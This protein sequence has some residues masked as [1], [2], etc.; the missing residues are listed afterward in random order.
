MK[1]SSISDS[2][3]FHTSD[4]TIV[5]NSCDAYA[6]VLGCFFVAFEKF[7]PDCPYPIVINTESKT[8]AR[9]SIKNYSNG[10]V[11][12]DWGERFLL[13]LESIN[14]TYVLVLY[15]DFIL[16][17]KVENGRIRETISFIEQKPEAVVAYLIDTSLELDETESA[18]VFLPVAGKAEYRLN[19]APAIWRRESLMHYTSKGDTPWAWEAFGTYRTFG[20]QNGF[21]S[22][23]PKEKSIYPY[24]HSKGGAIYRGK[25]VKDVVDQMLKEH[26]LE[27]NW[28]ERGF[29]SDAY[30]EKRSLMWKIRFLQLGFKMVGFKSIFFVIGYFRAK[31][32]AL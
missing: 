29:S 7:W 16:N 14:T 8:Y 13:S 6:D 32:N 23:N 30:H 24:N 11:A 22:L 20:D 17:A 27:V 12:D 19:S 26:E 9:G 5:I 10:K 15:D 31:F 1:P 2:A 18:G 4:L 28:N 25:W 3:S 21:Y